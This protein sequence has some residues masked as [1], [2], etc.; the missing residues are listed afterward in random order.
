MINDEF[1]KNL[2]M[3]KTAIRFYVY[4]ARKSVPEFWGLVLGAGQ[5]GAALVIG[6]TRQLLGIFHQ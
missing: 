5:V 4:E 3:G 1:I 2:K 6:D